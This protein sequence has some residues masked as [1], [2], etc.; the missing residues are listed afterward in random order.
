V[1]GTLQRL[2][3]ICDCLLVT[4]FTAE[5]T[6]KLP[7]GIAAG[8]IRRQRELEALHDGDKIV[9]VVRALG[10]GR[11][12]EGGNC[13]D[14]KQKASQRDEASAHHVRMPLGWGGEDYTRMAR[15]RHRG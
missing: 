9:R 3:E 12:A 1:A 11:C 14:E 4:A 8:D 7:N 2:A 13:N 15:R 5:L 6:E 10:R